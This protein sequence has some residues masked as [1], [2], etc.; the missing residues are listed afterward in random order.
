[1]LKINQENHD[2]IHLLYATEK[3]SDSEA[4]F[5]NLIKMYPSS[6]SLPII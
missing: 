3:P 5:A 6:A 4:F 1:M 2:T